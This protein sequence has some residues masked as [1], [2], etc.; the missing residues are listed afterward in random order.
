MPAVLYLEQFGDL[1]RAAFGDSPYLV[2][3]CLRKKTGWR[4]VDVRLIL[5]DEEYAEWGF[6]DPAEGNGNRNER[7]WAFVLAFSELGRKM[8]GLP[9]DFQIQQMSHANRLYGSSRRHPRSSLGHV[10]SAYVNNVRTVRFTDSRRRPSRSR[11]TS[12]YRSTRGSSA[13]GGRRSRSSRRGRPRAG[14]A[15]S[16]SPRR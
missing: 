4:D 11:A 10:P 16:S 6:G 15:G 8:T 1:V 5:T 9:V 7:W 13:S 12:P 3:S 2:G 14:R